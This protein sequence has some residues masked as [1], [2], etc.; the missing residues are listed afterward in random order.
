M[1]TA[2][3]TAQAKKVRSVVAQT[4]VTERQAIEALEAE[5]WL[6]T[7]A[8]QNI[9]AEFTAKLRQREARLNATG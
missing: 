9:R 5:E 2:K 3:A 6:V 8:V 7:E 4:G 1:A